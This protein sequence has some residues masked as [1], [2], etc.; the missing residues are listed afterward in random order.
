MKLYIVSADTYGEWWGAQISFFGVYDSLEKAEKAIEEL[1]K[2]NNYP[3]NINEV[4]LN[5]T[6]EIYLGGYFE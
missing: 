5:E 2:E 3:F 1:S 4:T 6:N